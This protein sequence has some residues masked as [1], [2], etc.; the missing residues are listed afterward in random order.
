MM[1]DFG[2]KAEGGENRADTA[3]RALPVDLIAGVKPRAVSRQMIDA[4][5]SERAADALGFRSREPGASSSGG[6]T[7]RVLRKK[8]APEDTSPLA[9]RLRVSLHKRF[10][11]YADAHGGL[12]YPAALER[13]LD[14]SEGLARSGK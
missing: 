1:S 3:K 12:S 11:A 5:E 4:V 8:R 10:L 14:E 13:L 7:T 2:L 6:S 9:L